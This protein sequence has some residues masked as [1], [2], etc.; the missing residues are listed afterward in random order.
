MASVPAA[1][2]KAY[3]LLGE[4]TGGVCRTGVLAMHI[5]FSSRV[6]MHTQQAVVTSDLF[7]PAGYCHL[8]VQHC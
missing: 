2:W 8:D 1:D 6:L 5:P 3:M 7:S 4:S